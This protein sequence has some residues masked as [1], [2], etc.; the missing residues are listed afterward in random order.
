MDVAHDGHEVAAGDIG[1]DDDPALHAFAHNDVRALG[2]L[3]VRE[4]AQ[5]HE[6]ATG[7]IDGDGGDGLGGT[8]GLVVEAQHDV[9]SFLALEDLRD[10]FALEG[11]FAH[12]GDLADHHAVF[13]GLVAVEPDVG[14]RHEHLLLDLQIDDA[15]D[16]GHHA[17]ELLSLGAQGGEV[18][19]ENLDCDLGAHAGEQVVDAVR[20][21]LAEVDAEAGDRVEPGAEVVE[22]VLAAAGGRLQFDLD[23]RGVD[24]LG[25]VVEFGAAGA[26][27]GLPDLGDF[28]DEFLGEGADA[29]GLGEGDAGDG[30]EVDGDAA[31]VEGRQKFAAEERHLGQRGE[32]EHADG[33]EDEPGFGE[34]PDEQAGLGG[35]DQAHQPGILLVGHAPHFGQQVGG[36]RGGDGERHE[37]R[38][39]DRDDAGDAERGEDAALDTA[40][41]EQRDEH[42]HDDDRGDDDGIAHFAGGLEDDLQRGRGVRLRAI[43]AEAAENIFHVHDG[44]VHQ[45][46]DGDSEAAERH[47]V[48]RET[49]IIEHDGRHE[50][51]DRNRG[52]RDEGRA[53]I[54]EEDEEHDDDE[55]RAVA[56]RLLDVA[57]G[58]FDELALAENLAVDDH[59]C[60]QGF[61]DGG[62]FSLDLFGE[63]D[64]VGAGLF[65]DRED[66]GGA[67][68]DAGVAAFGEGAAEA[69]L[70]DLAEGEGRGAGRG[71]G[72]D[73]V[74]EIFEA[75]DAAEVAHEALLVVAE[76]ETAGGVD[77]GVGDGLLDVVQGDALRA[78]FPGRGEH[79]VLLHIAAGALALAAPAGA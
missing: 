38:G 10:G 36:E 50:H 14:L 12:L 24:A 35:L 43:L 5:R 52:E 2:F 64:G 59:A 71:A 79:L 57:D 18:F 13:G 3:D 28:L 47:G 76:N 75:G 72:H 41:G 11:E 60:G 7:R 4:Q 17:A 77:V 25:V 32:E 27:A 45:F 56:Q 20:D 70:G 9:E 68:V 6:A 67:A 62:E 63:L 40:E 1:L 74:G 58:V 53:E 42:E 30:D 78:E 31:F 15:R 51:R 37:E 29:V 66:D 21:G 54:E 69:D 65:L 34:G 49:E 73:G 61:L 55:D 8:A 39:D 22:D 16:C 19:A 48:D 33:G 44:V 23:L 26:A 46:A